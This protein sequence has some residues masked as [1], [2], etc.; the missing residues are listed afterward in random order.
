MRPTRPFPAAR[1]APAA[2]AVFLG[3]DAQAAGPRTDVQPH[4]VAAAFG[5]TIEAVYPDGRYQR[6]WLKP[7]G[8]WEAIGRRGHWSAGKWTQ[9]QD[10]LC[11]KQARPFPSPFKYCTAFPSD[12]RIGAVWTSRAMDGQPIRVTLLAGIERPRTSL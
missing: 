9:K 4:G 7:D 2:Y 6:L 8:S 12:G 11:L 3:L 10:R 5:N 1:L